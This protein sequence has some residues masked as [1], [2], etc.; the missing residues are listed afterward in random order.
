MTL[1]YWPDGSASL[2]NTHSATVQIDSYEIWSA[3]NNLDPV[4]WVSFDDFDDTTEGMIELIT[5][6][7]V[8]AIGF[9]EMTNPH[10]GFLC[11]LNLVG[12]AEFEVGESWGIGFPIQT[13]MPPC[14]DVTFYY[15]MPG[16]VD[17]KFLGSWVPEPATL[18]LLPLGGLFLIFKRRR[19]RNLHP[20][21]KPSKQAPAASRA[22]CV[23]A[24]SLA[25]LAA[26]PKNILATPIVQDYGPFTV[27]F[28]NSGDS[29]G[30]YAGEK[31]W[32]AQEMTD[33]AASIQAW[34]QYIENTQGRQIEMHLF[35]Q[36]MDPIDPSVLGGSYSPTNGD[37]TTAWNYGEHVWR[38]GANYDG[39]WQGWDTVIRYDI[40]AAG[41]SWNLGS[42]APG[43]SQIDFR[44]VV[45]H[46]IGHSIGFSYTYDSN[47]IFDD[48]G[49]TWGSAS[50][51]F[52]WAGYNGLTEW[53]KDLVDQ[54]GNRPASGSTGTPG[55]F[56]QLGDVYF[57]G[58]DAVA[59]YGGPVPIYSPSTWASGSSLCH[60]AEDISPEPLMSPFISLGEEIRGPTPLELEVLKDLGYT[61]IPEPGALTLLA[62][63]ALTAIRRRKRASQ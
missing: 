19:T 40:T 25:V 4:G 59:F 36:E 55:N 27:S 15:T 6:L 56:D 20:R 35:W 23:L 48:W 9:G 12:H 34:D 54:N 32:T 50:D 57:T 26:G 53:D 44:S 16:Y 28:Y 24:A 63:G 17:V 8:D 11:E 14:S 3:G 45:T 43:P 62:L 30:M 60:L 10:S 5:A 49:N 47:P 22:A 21:H 29:N 13:P 38:D 58:D 41:Y 51:P 61:I 31:N 18:S 46:E 52:A 7:G 33:V 39:P 42:G 1:I 2:K 37:G